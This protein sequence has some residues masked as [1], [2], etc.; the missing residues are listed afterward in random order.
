MGYN[1]ANTFDSFSYFGNLETPDEQIGLNGNIAPT[2]ETIK[3]IKKYGF[4]TIRLPV[5]WMYFIDDEGNIDSEWM[6]RIKEVI[7]IITKEKLYCILNIYNDGFISSW[8]F[9][10]MESKDKYINVWTQ[11]AN[12]FKDYNEYLIFESMD[13]VYFLDY[14]TFDYDYATLINLNQAF[15]DTIRKSGGYNIERLLLIAGA[16]DDLEMTCNSNYKMPVD[17]SN[18]LA[19]SIH[20]YSPSDFVYDYYFEP[21]NWT[22]D[23]GITFTSV[24]N[25]FWGNSMDY[26]NLF[27][28]FKLMKS[29]FVDK[30]IPVIISEVG[31]YTEQK[32]ELESIREYLYM[33]F[34]LSSDIDGIMCSLWDTSNKIIGDMN[35]YDRTNDIWYDEKL[36]DNFLQISKGKYVKPMNYFINITFESSDNI[37][38]FDSILIYTKNRKVL[39]IFVNVKITGVLFLDLELSFY[40]NDKNGEEIQINYGIDN[41]K[42]QYDGTHIITIDV[43]GIEC[44]NFVKA[45]IERGINYII[46]K[47]MTLEFEESFLSIDYK[48]FK[49]DISSYIYLK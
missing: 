34:S 2:K 49:N 36:K 31:V 22:N 48:S 3:K 25:I 6:A 41:A 11:I 7:D 19:V 32:K 35:F 30:G 37:Y 28:D 44:Y 27:E 8:L 46:M 47:N 33:L 43:S 4:K 20:Y 39:K 23:E 18:K 29:C 13:E 21:Y 10:G 12:E 17:Q 16:A 9:K 15:V 5:T 24:P 26:F 14:Y 40:T 42:K 38:Y 1:I 45:K